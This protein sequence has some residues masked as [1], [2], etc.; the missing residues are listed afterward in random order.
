[1]V[2]KFQQKLS[3]VEHHPVCASRMLRDFF[4]IAQ[5]PLLGEE[6]KMCPTPPFEQYVLS[7]GVNL[8]RLRRYFI[9]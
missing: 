4:L 7:A 5:P 8:T 1:M 9:S 3:V 2:I 6:G